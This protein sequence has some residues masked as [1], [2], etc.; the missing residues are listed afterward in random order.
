MIY[1]CEF[2]SLT[3]IVADFENSFN[4]PCMHN[5]NTVL[6][7]SMMNTSAKKSRLYG[8]P[9]VASESQMFSLLLNI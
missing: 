8:Q 2:F 9:F 4:S 3:L 5:L 6:I 1:V 7:F